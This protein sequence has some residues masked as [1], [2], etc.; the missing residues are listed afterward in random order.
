MADVS[1]VLYSVFPADTAAGVTLTDTIR[2]TFTLE[3]DEESIKHNL[4]LE[5]PDTDEVIHNVYIPSTLVDGEDNLLSSPGYNGVVPGTFSF[6][7]LD[8]IAD[9]PVATTDTTGAGNL[10]RTRVIFTPDKPLAAD[11]QYT[12]YLVGDEDTGDGTDYGLKP[13]TVFDGVA[14]GGNT[15]T[16]EIFFSGSY[17]GAFATD[18]LNIRITKAGLAGTAEYEWWFDSAVLD[19][20]GPSLSSIGT[21]NVDQGVNIRFKADGMFDLGDEF[22]VYLK[23]E[24]ALGETLTSTFTTGGGSIQVVP[25]T[26]ATSPLGDPVTTLPGSS[27]FS[28]VS[29]TPDNLSTNLDSDKYKRITVEFDNDVDPLTV[30]DD[31][32]AVFAERVTDHPNLSITSPDGEIAKT[33]TASGRFLYIDL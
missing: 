18:T 7:R 30:T 24:P 16:G 3:M 4:I 23:R 14:A 10:Y 15:G 33:V 21:L 6:V 5:G 28:V 26:T 2:V 11:T 29:I 20:N 12:L 13:R 27:S 17:E 1:D 31:T 19:I 22:T 9:T 32:V 8:P 25:T